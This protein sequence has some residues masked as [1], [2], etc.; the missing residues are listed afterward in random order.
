MRNFSEIVWS[1]E[2]IEH[3]IKSKKIDG[4]TSPAFAKRATLTKKKEGEAHVVF[5]NPQ[6]K[7]RFHTQASLP[8]LLIT[9]HLSNLWVI[10]VLRLFLKLKSKTLATIGD[11]NPIK[12]EP[13]LTPFWF[14]IRSC[15]R[16][17][18]K[19]SWLPKSQWNNTSLHSQSGMT[20]MVIVTTNME[21]KVTPPRAIYH[22]STRS[23]HWSRH[24]YWTSIEIID[25]VWQLILCQ[26][27][28]GPLLMSL[29]RTRVWRSRLGWTR[30]SY[31]W[32]R[33]T[34]WWWWWGLSLK[35]KLLK[36]DVVFFPYG[37][38]WSHYSRVWRF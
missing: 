33:C 23:N 1:G 36:N 9:S 7:A 37:K 30:S 24:A 32:T 27:T 25:L 8:T 21:L 31:L 22:W 28:L 13:A 6:S 18:C 12:K 19:I 11:L 35:R 4:K 26:I 5:T 29:W 20:L 17:Y 2:L 38:C 16:G 3:A 34:K 10:I 15:C 14:L